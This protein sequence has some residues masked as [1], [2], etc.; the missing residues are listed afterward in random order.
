MRTLST[1]AVALLWLNWLGLA[2]LTA[3]RL[4]RFRFNLLDPAWT[5]LGGYAINYCL[6]PTLYLLN[7]EVGGIYQDYIYPEAMI[8]HGAGGALLFSFA[9]LLG[10]AVGDLAF[11]SAAQRASCRLPGV[12]LE[13][14]AGSRSYGAAALLFFLL[15]VAGLYGFVKT[16]GWTGTVLELLSGGQRDA[17]MQVILGHGYF[18]LAM[19]LSIVGWAL[20]CARWMGL[21]RPRTGARRLLHRAFQSGWLAGTLAIWIAFGERVSILSVLFI[22]L[23]FR[24]A[25]VPLDSEARRKRRRAAIPAVAAFVCFGAIAGPV[26]L[27]M[28]GK[29]VNATGT[30]AMAISAWDG[31]EFTV[32]AQRDI[33]AGDLHWGSTYF[34]DLVYTWLLRAGFPWKPERYGALLVQD[35][36][37]PDLKDNVGATFPTGFLVEAYANFW[38]FGVFL[39]PLALAIVFRILYHRI[40]GRDWFWLVQ[41][42]LLFPS[43]ASFRSLG[44]AG[45][46]LE[47]NFAVVGL[48]VLACS[49]AVRLN[50]AVRNLALFP[51]S[52]YGQA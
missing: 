43:L 8:R 12:P 15:G 46:A 9:G 47:A 39:V 25:L 41:A 32:A 16:A 52:E 42:A 51:K 22:P 11:K 30:V 2:S 29:E 4:R 5:F 10:F 19:Q 13:S 34:G 14:V 28:K 37:A 31:F 6:R 44:W 45:A 3:L 36:V 33:R 35:L 18:T 24:F 27:L 1:S 17:F 49:G 26:G 20:I 48:V 50:L 21:P 40:E 23:A 38:Y 7:P